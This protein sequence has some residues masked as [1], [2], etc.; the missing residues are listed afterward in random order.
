MTADISARPQNLSSYSVALLLC[1]R[2]TQ[3]WNQTGQKFAGAPDIV[4]DVMMPYPLALWV[5]ITVTYLIVLY[6]IGNQVSYHLKAG[7]TLGTACALMLCIPAFA[8]KLGF[9][10]RDAPELLSW[11]GPSAISSL[12]Q[13]PLIGSARLIFLT[14][15]S[16]VVWAVCSR[17]S[18]SMEERIKKK[19]KPRQRK[20]IIQTL[21]KP[22]LNNNHPNALHSLLGDPNS[23]H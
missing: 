15:G 23:R 6:R 2:I 3:R 10:A 16:E 7:V 8:F 11:L 14:I 21:M 20:Y 1:H 17:F 22:R 19:G 5:L 4:H 12:E 18:W 13:L 9:T